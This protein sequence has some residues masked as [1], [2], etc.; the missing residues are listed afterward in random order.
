ME[1]TN[2]KEVEEESIHQKLMNKAYDL[3]STE[4]VKN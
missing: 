4:E 2:K 1:E 3:W